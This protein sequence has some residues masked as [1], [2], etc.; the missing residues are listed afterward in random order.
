MLEAARG[1]MGEQEIREILRD[2]KTDRRPLHERALENRDV[3]TDPKRSVGLP[4][5]P[6]DAYRVTKNVYDP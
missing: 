4:L 1:M 2:W 5:L 6:E 3:L